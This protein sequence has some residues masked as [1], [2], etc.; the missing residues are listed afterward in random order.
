MLR[1]CAE[2][3]KKHGSGTKRKARAE[4]CPG[5]DGSGER[6]LEQGKTQQES[7]V[8]LLEAPCAHAMIPQ[9]ELNCGQAPRDLC[10]MLLT[11]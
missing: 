10:R 2:C 5:K 3:S 7:Q 6:N 1:T 4:A 11:L 9:N 8:N